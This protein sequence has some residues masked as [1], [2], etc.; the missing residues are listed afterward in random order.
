MTTY[1]AYI[2]GERVVFDES[3]T[4]DYG[5][6]YIDVDGNEYIVFEDT[7]EAG[8]KAREYW[9]DMAEDDPEE[10]TCIVGKGTLVKWALGQ[11]AGPGTSQVGSLEEWLDL[12]EDVPEEHWASYDGSECSFECKHPDLDHFTVAYRT[13]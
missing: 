6:T 9:A 10:F 2:E 4:N 7:E 13:N 11:S 5:C 8:E 1:V 12:W 3:D